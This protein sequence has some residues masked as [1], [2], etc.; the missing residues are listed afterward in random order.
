MKDK[1]HYYWKAKEEGFASRAAYKLQQMQK[2]QRLLRA[3]DTVLELGS[4]PGGWTEV[5]APLVG[6]KGKVVCVDLEYMATKQWPQVSFIEGDFTNEA[7]IEKIKQQIDGRVDLLLSDAAPSTSGIHLRDAA[8]S[9][10]LCFQVLQMAHRFLKPGGKFLCKM[11][12][13]DEQ[14]FIAECKKSFAEVKRLKPEASKK[15]SR[16]FYILGQGFK[17]N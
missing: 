5:I 7:V 14:P 13:G 2:S 10:E 16:E 15:Q 17:P 3:G 9:A 8:L 1:D 6:V 11:Y 4:A 12:A